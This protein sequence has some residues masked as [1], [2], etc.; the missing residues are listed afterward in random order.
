[1]AAGTGALSGSLT[2]SMTTLRTLACHFGGVLCRPPRTTGMLLIVDPLALPL[3]PS[4]SD[5]ARN[6]SMG[7]ARGTWWQWLLAAVGIVGLLVV[8][9]LSPPDSRAA[10]SQDWPPFVLVAGLLLIGVVA[11]ADGVFAAVGQRLA[12]SVKGGPALFV[13]AMAMVGVV[14]ALLNLDTSVA[15][16]TPVLVYAA[17][18]RGGKEAPFLYGCLLLSN[19]GS[20]LLPGSN[21]TNLIVIGHRHLSGVQFL[22][23]M[24]EP[25]LAAFCVT[26]AVV[27]WVH[28]HQ[29]QVDVRPPGRPGRPRLGLGLVAIGAAAV[30]VV[31]L[32]SPAL[33]V[34]LVGVSAVGMLLATRRD[35]LVHVV[36]VLN[37][38]VLVGLFGV[39]VALGA[40]G[41]SWSGPSLLLAHVDLWGTAGLAAVSSVLVNNLPAASILAARTPPHPFALLIG[42]NLGPNLFMTGSLAWYL[43]LRTAHL[44]GARPSVAKV[45]AIG[46]VAVPLSMAAA[47]GMLVLV[48]PGG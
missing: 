9:A 11:N 28:R 15:F 20:L 35:R 5:L 45:S 40:L 33:P 14:T 46:A 8:T 13:G 6:N 17:R 41:R 24:W 43:W 1:M 29:L 37:L 36:G 38:P 26:A 23:H 4:S 30:L 47:L 39:A 21:L 48:G 19:A 27:A 42:L 44:V 31:G 3:S 22:S 18:S 7:S 32:S 16:L 2:E 12:W 10:M 25:A 34:L